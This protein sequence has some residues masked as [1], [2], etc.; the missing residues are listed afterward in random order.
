MVQLEHICL[1]EYFQRRFKFSIESSICCY[2]LWTVSCTRSTFSSAYTTMHLFVTDDVIQRFKEA[3]RRLNFYSW[4]NRDIINAVLVVLLTSYTKDSCN[5]GAFCQQLCLIWDLK[6]SRKCYLRSQS[7][8]ICRLV[9]WYIVREVWE[10]IAISIYM[11]VHEEFTSIELNK[12]IQKIIIS[13]AA[14]LNTVGIFV[15]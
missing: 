15:T 13:K 8:G 6:W 2:C 10:M 12:N 4:T 7:S 14:V 11:A 1:Y 3:N 9:H 5:R